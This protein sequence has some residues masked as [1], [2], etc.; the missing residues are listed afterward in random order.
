MTRCFT[1][2]TRRTSMPAYFTPP[3]MYQREQLDGLEK[4]ACSSAVGGPNREAVK[5]VRRTHRGFTP[6]PVQCWPILP[7]Q[8][9]Q[10]SASSTNRCERPDFMIVFAALAAT[11]TPVGHRYSSDGRISLDNR[12]LSPSSD[13]PLILTANGRTD[14]L[15]I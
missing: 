6:M 9:P 13:L 15:T 8:C 3:E 11:G 2:Q 5:R 4:T 14:Q 10:Q 7:V 12:L 1:G